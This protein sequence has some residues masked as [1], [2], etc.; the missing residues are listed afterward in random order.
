M[1]TMPKYNEIWPDLFAGLSEDQTAQ[2]LSGL[3]S[4]WLDGLEPTREFIETDIAIFTGEMTAEA[5]TQEL[6]ENLGLR[7]SALA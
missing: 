7:S 1:N 3:A 5:A 4:H 6:I 2:Y